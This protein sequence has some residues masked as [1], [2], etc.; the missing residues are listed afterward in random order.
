LPSTLRIADLCTMVNQNSY[1]TLAALL[2]LNFPEAD[3][4][5][6]QVLMYAAVLLLAITLLVNIC[7]AAVLR[8][9]T[10]HLSGERK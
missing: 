7:G 8:R 5:Q 3:K 9:A 6:E 1:N 2:A 4:P 10:A